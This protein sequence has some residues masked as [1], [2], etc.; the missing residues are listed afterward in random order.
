MR[1]IDTIGTHNTLDGAAPGTPF[2]DVVFFTEAIPRKLKRE[3]GHSHRLYVCRWQRDLVIAV[4]RSIPFKVKRA[5][6]SLAHPGVPL[7]TPH[8]G[9]FRLLG[10]LD[11]VRT[12]LE[13]AHR[14]NAA[15]PP[16]KRGERTFRPLMWRRHDRMDARINRALKRRGYT[17]YAG[18][19]ANAPHGVVA[20]A[21]ELH[22]V[23]P[24]IDR[25][26]STAPLD[27]VAVLSMRGSDHHR[28][29]A[30]VSRGR[31]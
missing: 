2:A 6:Y 20:Y 7:V 16:Y 19:D 27:D 9:T 4:H 3:L 10:R 22:E 8:R 26:G 25:L 5:R 23:G 31:S 24:G 17:V 1:L 11:G 28:L 30:R 21:G 29:R 15:F 12:A 14:I 13:D 18:G